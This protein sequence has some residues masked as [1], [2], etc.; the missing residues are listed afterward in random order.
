MYLDSALPRARLAVPWMRAAC[1]MLLL[2]ALVLCLGN[3]ARAAAAAEPAASTEAA[4]ELTPSRLADLLDDPATRQQLIERLRDQAPASAEGAAPASQSADANRS[5]PSR[6]AQG[7]QLFLAGMAAH[8]GQA[9]EELTA[10]ATGQ[11]MPAPQRQ[12]LVDALLGL[13]VAAAATVVAFLLLRAIAARIYARIDRWVARA[14]APLPA[15]ART[16]AHKGGAMSAMGRRAVAM[17]GALFIDLVIVLLAGA[18]GYLVALY[19]SESRGTISAAQSMFINAF[20][21]VEITKA[22]IRGIFATRYPMLRLFTMADDVARYW[23]DRLGRIAAVIGYGL[24]LAE[25]LAKSLL[26]PSIGEL[27]GLVIMVAAYSYAL[28]TIWRN[29]QVL[30]E[31]L[32]Q[33]ATRASATYF[34]TWFRL[35]A[36]SWHVLAIGYFTVLLVV[37]QVDTERALPFMVQATAQSLL[38]LGIGALLIVLLATVLTRRITLPEDVRRKLPMLEARVNAYVPAALRGLGILIRI[39]VALFV[40]DAWRVFDLSTWIVSDAGAAAV[41]M[42]VNVAIILLI[43]T[44]AWTVIASIIEHRLSLSEGSGMPTARERTLLSLF[45]NAALIVIVTLT[46]LVVLSQIGVDIAPLIAGAGVVGLAIGFGSQKLVQDIITGV[47]IQLENGMNQNDV[48]QVAGIFG[49]VEKI[50]IRSVGIRTLDGGYHLIP[51]S[52]VDVV[53]NHM[54]DFSYHLGEYTI[55]HR[56][57]V[58][59]AIQHL[60]LAFDEL[61]QDELLASEVLEEV[62]IPGV[63]ALS[64]KGVTI[65][66][67]IKTTPGMQWAVQRGYNRLVKKHF[68]AAGI[69]LPYPHTVVYFGQDK[70][71]YAPSANLFMQT[72]RPAGHGNADAAGHTRRRLSKEQGTASEDVLGNELDRV[73]DDPD[74]EP[75]PA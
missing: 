74:A 70:N 52:S 8:A 17:L 34:G 18:A 38:A 2:V 62:S 46:V 51:F 9:V 61:M 39:V 4:S 3:A 37:S 21:A 36:R 27:L 57:S 11:G 10:L 49:T 69:E 20:V 25:P 67:L 58:D 12:A 42:V 63:T 44:V 60:R 54:R 33:R 45:R 15:P 68:N 65:R 73:V 56:E 26:S 28:R 72:D 53:S 1:A 47:F 13:A 23:N 75:R 71:G 29:R 59:D 50:T 19:G 16:G 35:L 66:V 30:R 40:L 55:A 64:E 41:R 48:V 31:R 32:E 43:A 24:L 6:I 5:L 22:L 7:A 14:P